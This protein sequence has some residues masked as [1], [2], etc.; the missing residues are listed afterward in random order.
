MDPSDE[1]AMVFATRLDA[2]S[3]QVL[4]RAARVA[5]EAGRERI[6][7]ADLEAVFA[8]VGAWL[9]E[10]SS[11]E[12]I[13]QATRQLKAIERSILLKELMTRSRPAE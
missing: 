2:L 12:L 3:R 4:S 7:L 8:A 6:E 9:A 1:A 13:L 10:D 5:R 11:L